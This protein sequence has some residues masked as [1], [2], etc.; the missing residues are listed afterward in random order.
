MGPDPVEG[1]EQ[2]ERGNRRSK[3]D[4]DHLLVDDIRQH[5]EQNRCSRHE[6]PQPWLI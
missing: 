1:H 5:V 4:F 6:P 2:N 3:Q